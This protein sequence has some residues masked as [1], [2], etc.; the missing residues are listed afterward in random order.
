MGRGNPFL[1]NQAVAEPKRVR[2]N[3]MAIENS[4]I[5]LDDDDDTAEEV[6]NSQ[7]DWRPDFHMS[8]TYK[9]NEGRD[10]VTVYVDVSGKPHDSIKVKVLHCGSCSE[11][12]I[13]APSSP[14]FLD[15]TKIYKNFD[16]HAKATEKYWNR[17][18]AHKQVLTEITNVNGGM[19]GIKTLKSRIMLHFKVCSNSDG[20]CTFQASRWSK[21]IQPRNLS[22]I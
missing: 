15:V 13:I 2:V 21:F 19:G 22:V 10:C 12:L 20:E 11:L 16:V 8:K 4:I 1:A 9:N 17:F 5:Q 7:Q 14:C 3:M 6:P 18:S